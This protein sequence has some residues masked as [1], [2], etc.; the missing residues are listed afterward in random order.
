MK[1]TFQKLQL[2][3]AQYRDYTQFSKDNFSKKF[4]KIYPFEKIEKV[5][6]I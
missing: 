5:L 3:I 6:Q 2:I 4:W 1:T